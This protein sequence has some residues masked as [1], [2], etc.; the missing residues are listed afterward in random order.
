METKGERRQ[1][2]KPIV[3]VL[4]IT[5]S[6]VAGV[7]TAAGTYMLFTKSDHNWMFELAMA[8][9]LLISAVSYALQLVRTRQSANVAVAASLRGQGDKTP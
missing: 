8:L 4:I 6:F 5:F 1:L 3:V 7:M 2:S 9:F